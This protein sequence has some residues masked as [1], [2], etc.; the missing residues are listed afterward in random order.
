MMTNARTAYMNAS[1]ATADPVRLLVMLCD[2][3]TLDVQRGLS[4]QQA[5]D[6]QEAHNQ[7]IHAQAIVFELRASLKTDG[8]EGGEQLAAVYDHLDRQ[9]VTANIRQDQETTQHCLSLVQQIADTWRQA[10][11]QLAQP[12]VQTA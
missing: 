5:G 3:L 6:R 8:F 10:A 1:V 9:L 11:M 2:R 7:L 12:A 4:A